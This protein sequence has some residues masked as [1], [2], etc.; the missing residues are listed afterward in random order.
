MNHGSTVSED[1]QC[2]VSRPWSLISPSRIAMHDCIAVSV[3]RTEGNWYV[4]C[5]IYCTAVRGTAWGP[6]CHIRG[7]G[8]RGCTCCRCTVI[9]KILCTIQR[10][11]G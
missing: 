5:L 3:R 11:S 9:M 8:V 6:S 1:L 4:K 2:V 10:G 7:P